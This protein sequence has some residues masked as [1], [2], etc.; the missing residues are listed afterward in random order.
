MKRSIFNGLARMLS[1]LLATGVSVLVVPAAYGQQEV[2]PTSYDPWP[3]V[4]K[5]APEF[6]RA[7]AARK[8]SGGKV[9][10]GASKP[11]TRKTP[12]EASVDQRG[13]APRRHS[14]Q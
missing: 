11:V 8:Q 7:R 3:A 12:R 9:G 14:A 1:L 10:A 6:S 4:K 2:D 13:R 5:D